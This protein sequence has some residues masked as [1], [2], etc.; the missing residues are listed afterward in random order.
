VPLVGIDL[1]LLDE[2]SAEARATPRLRQ[3]RNFHASNDDTCHRLLNAVEPGTYIMPHRHLDPN[4]DEAMIVVRGQMGM[5]FFD[6]TGGVVRTLLLA[7]GGPAVGVD[8]PHGT[9]HTL[10]SLT[11][12]TVFFEAKGGP[13]RQLSAEEKAAWA[14]E[15]GDPSAFSY[16]ENLISLFGR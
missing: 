3:N 10:V 6:E 11:P 7:A 9:Y 5:V 13:Y 12:G 2:V 8:I 4:K 14:P 16:L 1:S 15:E